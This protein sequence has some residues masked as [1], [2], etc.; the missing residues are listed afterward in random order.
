MK[1]SPTATYDPI[2]GLLSLF[3]SSAISA[4]DS[5]SNVTYATV[6]RG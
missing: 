2:T 3:E 5:P 1:L 6:G 4:H